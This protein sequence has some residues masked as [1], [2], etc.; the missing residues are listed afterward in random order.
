MKHKTLIIVGL[1]GVVGLCILCWK[2]TSHN[3]DNSI[4]SQTI[5]CEMDFSSC[6]DSSN[7]QFIPFGYSWNT[8]T[9]TI[10]SELNIDVAAGNNV[11]SEKY[12]LLFNPNTVQFFNMQGTVSYEFQNGRLLSAMFA[13]NLSEKTNQE[14]YELIIEAERQIEDI[15]GEPTSKKETIDTFSDIERKCWT[16]EWM[17]TNDDQQTSK[18]VFYVGKD[19]VSENMFLNISVFAQPY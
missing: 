15:L 10:I 1:I 6:Y 8:T 13:P 12:S 18:F 4:L 17:A 9:A 11:S 2:V 3:S 19:S 16:S 7:N 5:L 14:R